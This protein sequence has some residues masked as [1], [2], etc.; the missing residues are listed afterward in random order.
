MRDKVCSN[1][2][3]RKYK[4]IEQNKLQCMF[5]GTIYTDNYAGK[6]EEIMIVGANE[7][8][9]TLKFK[10]ALT[11]FDEILQLYPNSYQAYF[12]KVQ[13]KFKVVF[14]AN[15]GKKYPVH[16]GKEI[17]SFLEDDDYK[18]AIELAPS[19]IKEVYIEQANKIEKL[20][21]EWQNVASKQPNIDVVLNYVSSKSATPVYN[22]LIESGW[23]VFEGNLIKKNRE[24]YSLH[25]INTCKCEILLVEN[26]E[27]LQNIKVRILNDRYLYRIAEK[28]RFP[29]S[30][31]VV[32]DDSKV[33]KSDL[34]KNLRA[35]I[36]SVNETTFLSD[37]KFKVENILKREYNED[38]ALT[39]RKLE[40]QLQTKHSSAEPEPIS[41]VE[42][43]HY[44]VETLPI[45]D[46]NKIRWVFLSIQNGD[47]ETA[48]EI[49]TEELKDNPNVGEF[50]FAML[51]VEKKMRTQEEFFSSISN[52][53]DK[54]KLE[55]IIKYS[56]KDFA[57][58]FV[59]KW[60]ELIIK[61]DSED[62]YN[63][64]LLFLAQYQNTQRQHFIECAE[65]KAIETLNQDLIEKVVKCYSSEEEVINFY[66]QLAQTS[67]NEEY[68]KK[69][70]QIDQT[71]TYSQFALFMQNFNNVEN[72]LTYKNQEE[73]ENVL[74]YCD[75]NSRNNLLCNICDIIL[76]VCFYNLKQAQTQIDFYL[77]YIADESVLLAQLTKM[78]TILQGM[79][80]FQL[81]EK[82]LSLA[83][84]YDNHNANLYWS[85]MQIKA[86]CRSENELPM[87][88]VKFSQME[89]WQNLLAVADEAFTEKCAQIISA[90]NLYN[91]KKKLRPETLDK[92]EAKQK[93]ADFINRNNS[94]LLQAQQEL[95]LDI[96]YYKKQIQAFDIYFSKIDDATTFQQFADVLERINIR[97]DCMELSYESSISVLRIQEKQ[98]VQNVKPTPQTSDD[99]KLRANKV[100]KHKIIFIC[101]AV[102]ILV[103]TLLLFITLL[104]PNVIF[105]ILSQ[106]LVVGLTVL[107]VIVGIVNL[108][109]GFVK[110]DIKQDGVNLFVLSIL[111]LILLI[112][113]FFK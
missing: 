30:L 87:T 6:E 9:R 73:L 66:F 2:G 57:N 20:R 98:N 69:I 37:L 92:V 60:E 90:S 48:N 55:Q 88:S 44:K 38:V 74:Q 25:A 22:K 61:L 80:Y 58:D 93:L 7:K 99:V 10:Q 51:L 64:F 77:S 83:I 105:S 72:K 70:L 33:N 95:N 59:N 24:A 101:Q 81:A 46:K 84:K 82:Y 45:S 39:T 111:N 78:G 110:K 13:A 40:T 21:Q 53:A 62:Y 35:N 31:L 91:G 96:T 8:L 68:Y 41:P 11:D 54:E 14:Y 108:I 34:P 27:D 109:L 12:G 106:E 67:G 100:N 47:F 52:F 94:I 17:K 16:F 36:L 43:G 42:L 28:E 3:G 113:I 32:I 75:K 104:L 107:T 15:K 79:G 19:D 1:C 65:N 56:S 18:K 112:M 5:C 29:S 76:K 4:E 85:L 26:L 103:M 102:P 86:H 89:E 97:F 49:L 23:Q 71:H 50:Q 63:A